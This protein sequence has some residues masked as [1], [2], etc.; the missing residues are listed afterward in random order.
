MASVRGVLVKV[1]G[2]GRAFATAAAKSFGA[3]ALDIEPILRVPA[4]AAGKKGL[5]ADAGSS[6]LRVQNAGAGN[7]WDLAHDLLDPGQPFSAA[8]QSGIEA[9]EPDLEQE[10]IH[11]DAPPGGD[12]VPAA[13]SEAEFCTFDAQDGGG[14]KATG[15]GNAWNLGN[16]FSGLAEARARVGK[17]LEKVVVAHL[18]TGFDPT[19]ITLP[20]NLDRSLQRN[21]VKDDGR[22]D[23]A[24]DQTPPGMEFVRNRGHGSGTLSLLAGNRLDGTSPDWP[25]FKEY[26]GGAPLARII[27]VRIANWVVRL[28]HRHDGAGLRLCAREGCPCAVDEHGRPVVAGA[29]RCGQHRL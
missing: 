23:D 22:P 1:K 27:P 7:P 13:G 9:V 5:A 18:D 10:W 16:D 4:K 12:F 21:F 6:W 14:G 15:P 28:H 25:G 20:A 2:D 24:S 11:A 26:V 8:A 17:K 29:G 3:G 19:H